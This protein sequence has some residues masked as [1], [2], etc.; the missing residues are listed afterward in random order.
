ASA[1]EE[2]GKV[3]IDGAADLLG[4]SR[5]TVR[6]YVIAGRFEVELLKT[7]CGPVMILDRQAVEDEKPKLLAKWR[8]EAAPYKAPTGKVKLSPT[9]GLIQTY[10]TSTQRRWNGRLGG[11]KGAASGIHGA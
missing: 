3:T 11:P 4:L 9:G 8:E 5:S 6:N 2:R 10:S 7:A 1:C